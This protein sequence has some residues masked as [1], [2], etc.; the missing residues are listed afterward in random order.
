MS[1]CCL[2]ALFF[3]TGCGGG[4]AAVEK[5]VEDEAVE[6]QNSADYEKEMMGGGDAKK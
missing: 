1:C 4:N 5:Q 3:T 6:L 2:T